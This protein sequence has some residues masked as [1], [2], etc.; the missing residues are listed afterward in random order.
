M[1]TLLLALGWLALGVIAAGVGEGIRWHVA[2]CWR[3]RRDFDRTIRQLAEEGRLILAT[4][5]ERVL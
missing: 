2:M 4:E 5:R 1:T 3:R